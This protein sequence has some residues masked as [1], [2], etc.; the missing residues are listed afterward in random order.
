VEV[1]TGDPLIPDPK[2]SAEQDKGIKE[3]VLDK[4]RMEHLNVEERK[5][6]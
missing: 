3:R 4:P 6:L 2:D 1:D 5:S